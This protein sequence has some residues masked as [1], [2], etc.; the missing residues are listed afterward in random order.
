M[1]EFNTKEFAEA[2]GCSDRTIE[3]LRAKRDGRLMPAR[4]EKKRAI[5]TEE[6]ITEARKVLGIKSSPATNL[7]EDSPASLQEPRDGD[8]AGSPDMKPDLAECAAQI[9]SDVEDDNDREEKNIGFSS[10]VSDCT[11]AESKSESIRNLPSD[12]KM[13]EPMSE[14]PVV[15][16]LPFVDTTAPLEEK[17]LQELA[18]EGNWYFRRGDDCL[19]QGLMYYVEGGRRLIEAKRR[20]PHGQWQNWLK[21][22]FSLSQDTATNRMK[23]AERFGESHS[24]SIRSL[25]PTTAI[26]LLALPAGEEEDFIAAQAAAGKPVETQKVSEVQS[27]IN[28]WKHRN[29]PTVEDNHAK[30]AAVV[31]LDDAVQSIGEDT[32]P[33]NEEET[34]AD[35]QKPLICLNTGNNEWYTP[36]DIIEAARTVLGDIDLDPASCELANQT[37]KATKFFSADDNGLAQEW[38]GRI[39]LNPP[40]SNKGEAPLKKFV[41]KLIESDF[42]AAIV[43]TDSSTET[44]WFAKLAEYSAGI[45][46]TTRRIKFFRPDGSQGNGNPTRGSALFYFGNAPDKFFEIFQQF[47]WCAKKINA[48]RKTEDEP[49]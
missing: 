46:F 24:E 30:I 28:E 41:D 3:G 29:D 10:A 38:S 42:E 2:V 26:K 11:L 20:L 21:E 4:Y 8:F 39:W 7:F 34:Q 17:S 47:G 48:T 15:E 43:L 37:V 33:A 22:N 13:P 19:K 6:Q 18:D 49:H 36:A 5:Y 16:L 27:A 9:D 44:G 14:A 25:K 31:A 32:P 12:V 40:Y 1:K 35:E 45:C 23:L